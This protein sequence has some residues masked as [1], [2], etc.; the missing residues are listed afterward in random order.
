M[1][2]T[3]SNI[4][5]CFGALLVI[6]F[7]LLA[8][9]GPILMPWEAAVRINL[10]RSLVPPCREYLLGTDEFGRS[11]AARI[12]YG[13]KYSLILS[14][15]SVFASL[16]IGLSIGILIAY[17]GKTLAIV[18][19]AL[20]DMLISFPRILTALI[21]IVILGR[22]LISL[23]L[24]VG[25]STAPVFVRL[26]RNAT[27][28]LK[29]REFIE[30]AKALGASDLRIII[31]HI[32]P[33][34]LSPIIVQCSINI[35]EAIIIISGLSF[36]GLGLPPPIPEWG[37]MIAAGRSHLMTKPHVMFIPA[38]VLFLTVLGFNLLGDGLRDLLDPR[39]SRQARK[40]LII[41]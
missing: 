7:V 3:F 17:W 1:I 33:N 30:A 34:V 11:I 14:C 8:T 25:I 9:I 20:T 16:V 36:L 35:G 12:I 23:L 10:K 39:I 37:A 24:A 13:A 4:S 28:S 27:L 5:L 38:A 21:F 6:G 40:L 15:G 18:L 22:N 31:K 32:L 41:R 26:V 2:A 29:E 19:T